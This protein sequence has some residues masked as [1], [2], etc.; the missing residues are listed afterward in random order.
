M[1]QL[2][3]HKEVSLYRSPAAPLPFGA[4]LSVYLHLPDTDH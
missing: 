4:P 2:M 3:V 1:N